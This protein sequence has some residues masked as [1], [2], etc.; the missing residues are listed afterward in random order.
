MTYKSPLQSPGFLY[1]VH[2]LEFLRNFKN[3][4]SEASSASV[5]RY[6]KTNLVD[7]LDRAILSH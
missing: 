6:D 7:A 2:R 4:I 5:F 3:D 1:L